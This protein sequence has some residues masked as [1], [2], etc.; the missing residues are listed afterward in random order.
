MRLAFFLLF[1]AMP[2]WPQPAER[3]AKLAWMSGA[4][5]HEQGG[6]RVSESWIGPAN[7]LMVAANLSAGPG[8]K[9]FYEFLRIADTAD[10]VSY[11]ASPLGRPAVEF[12]VK[13]LEGQRV[14]FEN[15]AHDFPQRI[16]YWREAEALMARIEGKDGK[17]QQWRFTRPT[18]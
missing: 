3:V 10:G 13:S 14:V 15:L 12:K 1:L 7:G 2:A 6:E 18:S 17:H 16:V 8:T 11:F 9:R 5:V 4:W